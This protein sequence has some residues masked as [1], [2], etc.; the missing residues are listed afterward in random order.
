METANERSVTRLRPKVSASTPE[1]TSSSTTT[2]EYTAVNRP[3]SNSEKPRDCANSTVTAMGSTA[4]NHDS[5][6]A[7]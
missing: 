4:A 3:T 5:A 6:V 7:R 2:N 1:G